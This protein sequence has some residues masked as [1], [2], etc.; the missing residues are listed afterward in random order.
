VSLKRIDGYT[1]EKLL[2]NGLN[3]LKNYEEK[4]NEINVFPVTDG[5]TGTNMFLTLQHGIYATKSNESLGDYLQDLSAGM[6]LGARGNSGV[7]LS[8][9]FKGL[10][11]SLKFRNSVGV[12][13]LS[14][15]FISGYKTAYQAVIRPVEG[16]ILTVTREG[17]ENI[18]KQIDVKTPIEKFFSMYLAEIKKSL[19][20]TPNI[21][22]QLK[23]AG[24]VDSGGY[25]Y[26]LIIEGMEKLLFGEI[27]KTNN[28]QNEVQQPTVQNLGSSNF[29]S[30]SD[31]EMGYCME[32]IL[33]LLDKK[34][35]VNPFEEQ[36][37]KNKLLQ[38]GNSLVVVVSGSNVKVHIHTKEPS[39]VIEASQLY[40][41]F[42]TFKLENMQLQ[43][44]EIMNA[45]PQMPKKPIGIIAVTNG[46][47]ASE[48]FKTL[49]CDVV[50]D[51][52][53]TMN[54]SSQEFVDAINSL[55]ADKIIIFPNNS[56]IFKAAEQA[57]KLTQKDNVC[58]IPSTNIAE[59]YF[60][61]AMDVADMED[62]EE[63]YNNMLDG[64]NSIT[65]FLVTKCM[66]TCV[67]NKVVCNEG[68]YV[69]IYKGNPIASVN[70]F[71]KIIEEI[72]KYDFV[73]EKENCMIFL[74]EDAM[75]ANREELEDIICSKLDGVQVDF[76]EA[77]QKVYN[78]IIGLV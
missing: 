72:K 9:I 78:Y 4:V 68:E 38:L 55:N 15:A 16:T 5:D 58:I 37:Y 44:N 40:G 74:G 20:N 26:M 28:S 51:G 76:L 63:R 24:C 45:K 69:V 62:I 6:L 12:Y 21:L 46:D 70:T 60:A 19:A 11:E 25:G 8:Q 71:D 2:R 47:G 30:K 54:T 73:N 75:H 35:S 27:I 52:G 66:K 1:F 42:I 53:R 67:C 32:F 31:F 3:N 65:S 64:F 56:N 61:L 57:I 41:E 36:H 39:R 7:I 14:R 77:N 23:E 17:I 49:G 43:H 29:N 22:P 50:I 48:L 59:C 13:K 33:Q 34:T 18:K 10:A